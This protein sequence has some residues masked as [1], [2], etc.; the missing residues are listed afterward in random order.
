MNEKEVVEIV[1]E[2]NRK[3]I[4]IYY[5]LKVMLPAQQAH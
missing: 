2:Y 5:V 4:M 3:I 1:A